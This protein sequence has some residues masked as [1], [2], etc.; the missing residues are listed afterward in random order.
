MAV[1]TETLCKFL[2]DTDTIDDKQ[3]SL[4][5]MS[6]NSI[7]RGSVA[8]VHS[9]RGLEGGRGYIS[10]ELSLCVLVRCKCPTLAR[11]SYV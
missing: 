11:P 9:V 6:G 5:V 1:I 8:M 7:S 3:F 2:F 10:L 4:T